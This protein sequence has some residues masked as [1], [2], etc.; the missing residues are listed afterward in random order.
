MFGFNY[1]KVPPSHF[2]LQYS[3]GR[4]VRAGRGLAFFYFKPSASLV[5][6]P[7]GSAD[8][9]FI[10]N[11]ISGDF[12]ALTIQ[13]QLTFRIAEPEKVAALLNY[14]VSGAPNQYVSEDP[15]KLPLRL[16]NL[17]QVLVR[18]E[19]QRL[20]LREAIYASEQ[21]A[22][23]VFGKFSSSEA[24][25]AL[26][27]EILSLAIQAIK[28]IPEMV[29]AL[30]AEAREELLRRADQAIYDRRNAAVEQERRIKEN[31]LNTELAVE[32]KKRQIREAKVE[33]DLAVEAKEQQVRKSKL[34]GA[35]VLE[36]ERKNLVL[37]RTENAR[38]EADA[39]AYAVEASLKAFS[40]LDPAV[41]QMLSV[42]SADPRRMVSM[43]FK[44]LAQNATKIGNLNIT[45]DLLQ[46]LMKEIQPAEEK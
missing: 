1:I 10:F 22:T 3:N 15:Q 12:Q 4:K 33:A 38:T 11:E 20:P 46:M 23:S 37:A 6:I 43:A 44:E 19:I 39:Q 36:T 21:V 16:I 30:E 13:G 26:G 40:G 35:I 45:P 8:V 29:R 31:E 9:P 17:V 2:V 41:V 5:V 42:Q 32:A 24:L 28:P 14:T 7:V 18:A 27:V 34:N 25:T